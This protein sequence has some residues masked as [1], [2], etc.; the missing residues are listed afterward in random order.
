MMDM[1]ARLE[2][3]WRKKTREIIDAAKAEIL[4]AIPSFRGG[5]VPAD[6]LGGTPPVA[7]QQT[8]NHGNLAGLT[9]GDPHT[10]YALDT[11]LSGHEGAADPHP[12]YQKESEK[13]SAN[14]YAS[15]GADAKVPTAEM[16]GAGA[17]NTKFLRGDQTWQVPPGGSLTV[18]EEDGAPSV[19]GVSEIKFPNGSV[20]DNTGGSVS[21]SISATDSAA[22][23]DNAASEIHAVTEKA[24][25]VD[26]DEILIEDSADSYNKKRVQI[27]NLPG[28]TGGVT[29]ED[30]DG[31]PSVAA[32]TLVF[33]SGAVID[34]GSGT[35]YLV[36]ALGLL[37]DVAPASPHAKSDEFDGESLDA[38]W[39]IPVHTNAGWETTAALLNGTATI[40]PTT[41][42]T[43]S[44]GKYGLFGIRQAAPSGSFT[45]SAKC[46]PTRLHSDSVFGLWVAST[47]ASKGHIIGFY[48]NGNL[49]R[50]IGF[51]Y[52]EASGCGGYDG[53]NA[54]T[55]P[56]WSENA[57]YRI[58]WNASNSTLYFYYSM[59][60]QDWTTWTSR[61]SM[62]QP[63]RIGLGL[64]NNSAA[65]NA[66]D[67]VLAR[68]F[69][70]SEP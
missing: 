16:G 51:S 20:T 69:R 3:M 63:D 8:I 56:A 12:G 25:P 59:N 45:V 6:S 30:D 55:G 7:V 37:L 19:A 13:G 11:D 24:T 5:R 9:T 33:P 61:G 64:W 66:G 27:G 34:R 39:T 32:T 46:K 65:V 26:A 35:A 40:E 36:L 49:A 68:W 18:K 57:W 43:G 22:I 17:D 41:A 14:G 1:Q 58:T 44:T 21:V 4:A 60:G 67:Q 62:S 31:T 54:D 28:G 48:G 50:A 53:W 38:K 42:G 52:N 70:V 2:A 10:Q 23:H 15:L 29:V 47:S